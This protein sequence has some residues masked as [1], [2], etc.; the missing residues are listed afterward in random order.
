MLTVTAPD[1]KVLGPIAVIIAIPGG[2]LCP[3][4]CGP[5][6]LYL[7]KTLQSIVASTQHL[8]E[9]RKYMGWLYVK[10]RHT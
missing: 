2:P 10:L 9:V 3:T 1:I 6:G 5:D 8:V 7:E 4:P